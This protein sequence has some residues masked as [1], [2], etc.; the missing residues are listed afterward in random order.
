M[1]VVLAS[2]SPRRHEL[3]NLINLPH[4][5]DVPTCE[6]I[7]D[8]NLPIKGAIRQLA[9][10]KAI[11]VS[12]RHKNALII[13]ADTVVV[14]NNKILGKPRDIEE[15]KNM[16]RAL[17]GD[18][19]TVVTG[20]CFGINENISSYSVQTRVEFFPLTEEEINDYVSIENVLDKAGAYGIQGYASKFIKRIDGDYFNVMGLPLSFLYQKIKKYL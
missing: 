18:V 10:D 3:L 6:E 20:I 8:P 19:H 14:L 4:I 15:A 5:V 2:G 16:L 12:K 9:F 17:S 7:I 1:K 11:N 13:A